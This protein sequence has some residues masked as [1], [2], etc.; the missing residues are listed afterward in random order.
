[1]QPRAAMKVGGAGGG[2]DSSADEIIIQPDDWAET[3][4]E[5]MEDLRNR[6]RFN[7]EHIM[8][9]RPPSPP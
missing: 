9:Q 2:Q 6:Q 1:M 3:P 7:F 8:A 5:E 4:R